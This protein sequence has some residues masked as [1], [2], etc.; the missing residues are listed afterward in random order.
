MK[1]MLAASVV[2]VVLGVASA[3]AAQT[4]SQGSAQ[5]P[6]QGSTVQKAPDTYDPSKTERLIGCLRP[7]DT[8]GRYV[9]AEAVDAKLLPSVGQAG[10]QPVGTSGLPRKTYT[11]VGVTPPGVDLGK[12]LNHQIEVAGTTG[13]R[14]STLV[15]GPIVN[16]H[17]MRHVAA[18]CP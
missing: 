7:S 18:K 2:V 15:K 10:D 8:P 4:Q 5:S 6:S 9:L 13:E 3:G 12:H 17:T 1:R 11:L 16:M 14:S